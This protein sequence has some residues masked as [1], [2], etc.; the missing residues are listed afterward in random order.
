MPNALTT[1]A[2]CPTR[3]TQVAEGEAPL[4]GV[5]YRAGGRVTVLAD[6]PEGLAVARLLAADRETSLVAPG[7]AEGA[8][9]GVRCAPGHVAQLTGW[10]GAFTVH[11][12]R[13]ADS[14]AV[15]HAADVVVDLRAAPGL[16]AAL[17]APGHLRAGPEATQAEAAEALA[18]QARALRG[19]FHKPKY[20]LHDPAICAHDVGGTRACSRC[21][22]VCDAEAIRSEGGRIVVEPHLCQGCATCALA[23]PTG[24]MSVAAPN[25]AAL[26]A[27]VAQAGPGP[28]TVGPGPDADIAAAPAAQFGEELWFAALAQGAAGVS[29][30]A[31][32]EAPPR[33]RAT[34]EARAA[35]A[36]VI[37]EAFGLGPRAVALDAP[38]EA[39][40]AQPGAPLPPAGKRAML[41]A[42]WAALEPE[43]F[44]GVALPEG[45]T[46]GAI[47]V[48]RDACV[49]CGVCAKTCPTGAI[50]FAEGERAVLEFAEAAC[51]QCGGCARICP[52][53]AIA[54]VPRLAPAAERND[55]REAN[56]GEMARCVETGRPYMSQRMLDEILRRAQA[57]GF[58]SP[59]FEAQMRRC[60]EARGKTSGT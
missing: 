15:A 55:W 32:A 28:L 10:L 16:S 37:A 30:R 8:T 4:G 14:H 49:L 56:S 54:L 3:L 57:G 7:I 58:L 47:A 26:L 36:A 44:A 13:D 40:A 20:F 48:D 35:A 60:P 5:F 33:Q 52:K 27:Q 24:A 38:A 23:C 31:G 17:P 43:G 39:V 2:R 29:L 6:G 9:D 50:R 42:A 11:V 46:Q 53:G 1:D 41:S 25:R 51:I 22:D 19:T 12:A 34:L 59:A 45:A 18:A 21:L